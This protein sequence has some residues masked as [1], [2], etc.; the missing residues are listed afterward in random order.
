MKNKTN[1]SHCFILLIDSN[2]IIILFLFFCVCFFIFNVSFLVACCVLRFRFRFSFLLWFNVLILRFMWIYN[3][4]YIQTFKYLIQV[5]VTEFFMICFIRYSFLLLYNSLYL[6]RCYV[7]W[8]LNVTWFLN[9]SACRQWGN[10]ACSV[11]IRYVLIRYGLAMK[12][13]ILLPV[14]RFIHAGLSLYIYLH[15]VYFSCSLKVNSQCF[16]AI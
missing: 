10:L 12:K 15:K 16:Y 14:N 6:S 13:F 7:N 8:Y 5:C 3:V 2:S 11:D 9:Y 1:I 4:I